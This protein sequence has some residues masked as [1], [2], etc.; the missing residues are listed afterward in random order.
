MNRRDF[1]TLLGGATPVAE[2]NSGIRFAQ[3]AINISRGEIGRLLALEN[4]AV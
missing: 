1:I 3:D 2:R 4:P